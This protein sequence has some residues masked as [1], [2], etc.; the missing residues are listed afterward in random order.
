[1]SLE[2]A[3]HERWSQSPAL[4]ALLPAERVATGRTVGVGRPYA[5]LARLRSRA[6]FHTN[7]GDSLDEVTLR[8][9]VWHD[10][11]DAGL[12]IL[13][14]IQAAFDRSSFSLAGN[15]RV[16]QMRR[17]GDTITAHDDGVWQLSIAFVVYVYLP[18]GS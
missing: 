14:Q 12:A 6:T 15:R 13:E 7:T 18:S 11:Y 2:Q 4:A 17:S 3:L 16:V 9:D 1:V 5:T 10:S 8:I